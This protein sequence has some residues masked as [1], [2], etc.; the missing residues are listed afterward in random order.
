MGSTILWLCFCRTEATGELGE[1]TFMLLLCDD[2]GSLLINFFILLRSKDSVFCGMFEFVFV[3]WPFLDACVLDWLLLS[4]P[5]IE[6]DPLDWRVL[7]LPMLMLL[8]LWLWTKGEYLVAIAAWLLLLALCFIAPDCCEKLLLLL[9]RAVPVNK[10]SQCSSQVSLRVVLS[11]CLVESSISCVEF[12]LRITLP[13]WCLPWLFLSIIKWASLKST[14]TL[15]CWP[16]MDELGL[17]NVIFGWLALVL[18]GVKI[19]FFE[20]FLQVES[21]LI[22]C[23]SS[24]V[25]WC[26]CWALAFFENASL[27]KIREIVIG[28]NQ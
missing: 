8:K 24:D 20:L 2:V 26:C 7:L 5:N 28:W 18:I 1:L 17:T 9:L 11:L 14:P 3:N 15:L 27:I 10:S 19:I 21:I 23:G 12:D 22:L 6:L 25:L 13:T 16:G 4:K